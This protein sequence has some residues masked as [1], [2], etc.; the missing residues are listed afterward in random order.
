MTHNSKKAWTTI[1]KLNSEKKP[2]RVAAVTP[3][4]VANQLILNGK[5]TYKERGQQKKLKHEMDLALQASEEQFEPFT[6]EEFDEALSHL[7]PGKA[8]GIDGITTEMIQ[9][10]GPTTKKWILTLMN[11]C[12]STS[13]IPK[14]WRKAR[15]VALLKP[16]KDPT[17]KKATGLS[18]SFVSHI[19]CMK[20]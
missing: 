13:N 9:H 19:N 1:K 17:S 15:V 12:A 8:A 11:K 4:E 6:I 20:G 5:P 7:K 2:Q 14:T 18:P 16:G 3:N 10:F